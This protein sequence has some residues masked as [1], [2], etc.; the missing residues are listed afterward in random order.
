MAN[1]APAP[2]NIELV[3]GVKFDRNPTSHYT[4]RSNS[5]STFPPVN[6]IAPES[7]Q[8]GA[9]DSSPLQ[10]FAQ[11]KAF[12]EPID[13]LQRLDDGELIQRFRLPFEIIEEITRDYVPAGYG[14]ETYRSQAIPESV[15][16]ISN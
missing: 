5:N 6:S 14:N 3:F 11:G 13:Y 2:L 1:Q 8:N 10:L 9:V 15:Q 16:V 7:I 4:V 12:L